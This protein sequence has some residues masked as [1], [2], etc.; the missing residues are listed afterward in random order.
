MKLNACIIGLGQVGIKFDLEKER[1]RS[2][3]IWTHFSAYEYL[4]D[5]YNLVAVVDP[6]KSSWKYAKER[7]ANIKCFSSIDELIDSDINLNV[8]SICSP[9]NF[10]DS[11]L[12]SIIDYVDAIFLE[13]P[14]TTVNKIQEIEIFL[15]KYLNKKNIYVNYY[16]RK[17]PSVLEM[18]NSLQVNN[19]TI[20]YIECRYSGPFMAV[21]S[22]ALDLLNHIVSINKIKAAVRHEQ[23]EG[24]G[25][26]S[27]MMGINNELINLAYTGKRHNFVFELEVITDKS[28][29]RLNKNLQTYIH[30]ELEV[31]EQYKG[32]KE[33]KTKKRICF[34]NKNRFICYLENIHNNLENKIIDNDNLN[35]SINSQKIIRTLIKKA[36]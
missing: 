6:D 17:E 35:Q 30:E 13:K 36:N 22:H 29:F 24:D 15:Q 7:S 1:Q 14:I 23:I 11:N 32:Y 25:Y 34:E 8:A 10:H 27:M 33:F 9:D 28:R 21:G 31:S 2:K 5:K 3:E 12:K 19:Q 26:S 18:L 20:K 16:K 4:S